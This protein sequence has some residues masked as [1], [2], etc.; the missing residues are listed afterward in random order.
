MFLLL[1]LLFYFAIEY[2]LPKDDGEF[3]QFCYVD[4]NC[5]VRGASTPFCFQ[6]AA[7]TSA[8][9]SLLVISTQVSYTYLLFWQCHV[10]CTL[11]LMK[12]IDIYIF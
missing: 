8:D 4:N 9:C 10:R 5:Q 1:Y 3:Y 2:Y 6:N 11:F 12:H 7:E